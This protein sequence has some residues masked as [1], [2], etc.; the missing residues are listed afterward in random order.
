MYPGVQ[1]QVLCGE[2][3]TVALF[4][5]VAPCWQGL[6]YVHGS[7][8]AHVEPTKPVVHVQVSMGKPPAVALFVQDAPFK[9]P[10]A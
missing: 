8:V 2:P 7:H 1:V 4:A 5:Q 6:L 9:Q 10:F 3:L